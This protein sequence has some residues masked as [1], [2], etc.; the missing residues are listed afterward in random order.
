[1]ILET[2]PII[3]GAAM[4]T[5]IAA[6]MTRLLTPMLDEQRKRREKRRGKVKDLISAKFTKNIELG[7]QDV[8]DIARGAD[9][10]SND[11]IEALY[12]LYA[13][14]DDEDQHKKLKALLEDYNR[15]EP[16]QS[17]PEEARPSLARISTLC[18]ESA[19]VTDRELLHPIR[20][21]LEEYQQLKQD[22]QSI[23]RQSWISYIIAIVSFFIGAIGLILA[24]QGPTKEFVSTEIRSALAEQAEASK[25]HQ[26]G[27][28]QPATRSELQSD[29]S[30]KPQS[31][32]EGRQR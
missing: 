28:G 7:V 31:E 14:S 12:E 23:K 11:G 13:N 25:A 18:E 5:A 17:L 21:L 32:A 29:V 20:K 8:L 26:V 22:H 3:A 30:D 9:A 27:A 6:T 2:I 1:M 24:F 19:L 4:A 15:E 10:S 16:F